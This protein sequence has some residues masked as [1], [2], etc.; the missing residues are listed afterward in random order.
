MPDEKPPM[1]WISTP[2]SKTTLAT[3]E[4][5]LPTSRWVTALMTISRS[6]SSGAGGRPSRLMAPD[7]NRADSG[8]VQSSWAIAFRTDANA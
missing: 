8:G 7:V 2:S 5:G 6:A 3:Y 1:P 4:L